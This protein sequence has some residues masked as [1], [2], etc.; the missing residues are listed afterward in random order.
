MENKKIKNAT[1]YT[2]DG[3]TFKSKLEMRIYKELKDKGI[4]PEYEEHTYVLSNRV[5]PTVGFYERTK[6]RKFHYEMKPLQE[7]TYTP[8]FIFKYNHLTVILEAKG[9]ANDVYPVKKNLFRKKLEYIINTQVLFFEIKTLGDLKECLNILE[10]ETPL[11][12]QIRK[13]ISHLPE[14]D[15][16]LANKYL[17]QRDF[18][19][20]LELVSSAI[21]RVNKNKEKY[22]DIEVAYLHKLRE[23]IY[24]YNEARSI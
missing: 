1:R 23:L 6:K 17:E 22:A 19:S 15:I 21:K 4:N 24:E 10:M 20:L 3:I 14:K 7:I 12:T 9:I 5:R 16:S 13:G 2:Y 11:V 18:D 8:D